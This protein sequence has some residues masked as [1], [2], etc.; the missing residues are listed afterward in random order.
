MSVIT[1]E[2]KIGKRIDCYSRRNFK[3][4]IT[5][6][7]GNYSWKVSRNISI[8]LKPIPGYY[9]SRFTA[10]VLASGGN[11]VGARRLDR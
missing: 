5:S 11:K 6:E 2:L 3:F 8:E 1:I 10:A 7:K 4:P 9:N